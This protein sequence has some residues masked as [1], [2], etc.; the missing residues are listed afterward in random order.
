MSDDAI[1]SAA[2]TLRVFEFFDRVE[3]SAGVLEIAETLDIPRSSAA[4]LISA[5]VQAGYLSHDRA[6]RSY[7]PTM[8]L[9]QVGRWV[10]AAL[11]GRDRSTLVPLLH[12]VAREVDET[13]VLG[14]QDDLFVQ[15]VHVELAQRPVMY[16]QRAGARRPMCRSATG[17]ALLTFLGDDDVAEMVR[18]H[19]EHADD[20]RVAEAEVLKRVR[21]AR[22]QG[23]ALSLGGF[24][25]GVAMLAMPLAS[26]D[27]ER[28][29]ALGVGGPEDRIRGKQAAIAKAL[30]A[31]AKSFVKR[32]A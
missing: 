2:R 22:K 13:V 32:S 1:K 21:E 14:V 5:L 11:L 16:F 31:C 23:Y 20:K 12:E 6:S 24:L 17:W 18:R 19:N 8:K 26:S 15:Y 4:A 3:R 10:E 29:Y 27:G 7:M 25:P 9:A 28:R 30:R